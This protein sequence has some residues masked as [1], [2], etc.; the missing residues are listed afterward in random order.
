[1]H[2]PKFS[3]RKVLASATAVAVGSGFAAAVVVAAPAASADTTPPGPAPVQ[4]RSASN[5]TADVLPTVQIDGVVWSQATMGNTVYAGGSFA[6]ARPAG[7]AAGTNLTPRAN[8]LAYDITTGNLITT[9]APIVERAGQGR[10]PVAGRHPP[11]RGRRTSRPRTARPATASPRST[12]RTGALS[13]A[14]RRTV[15]GTVDAIAATNSTVYF[16]GA[17]TTP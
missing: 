16:G 8:L 1:M 2:R 6:N 10:Q 13:R 17:F 9:F 11:V 7:A 12:R 3:V 4:Q 5:V 14:S 15:N